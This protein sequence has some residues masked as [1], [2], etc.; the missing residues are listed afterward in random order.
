M[1]WPKYGRVTLKPFSSGLTDEEWR[2]F[3]ETF[4]DGEIAEWN[5]S[6]PLRMPI[7]LFKRV[8]MGEVSRGDRMGFGILDQQGEWIGTVELYDLGLQ[9]ATLGILIGAK[10]RWGQGYGTE[11][12]KAVLQHAFTKMGL[13]K[14]K[15]R[16]FKHNLRAQRSFQKAGFRAVGSR[17]AGVRF[18]LGF[19]INTLEDVLME[20]EAEEWKL[21]QTQ[22]TH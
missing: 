18:G 17:P 13:T 2:R 22:A 9:Q 7:W 14:I 19:R 3:Y 11:A 16:T 21:Q 5:G 20:I 12:V 6:K 4:R 15:L 10:D 1:D 8:V